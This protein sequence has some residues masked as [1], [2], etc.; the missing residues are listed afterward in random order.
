MFV[1]KGYAKGNANIWSEVYLGGC[2]EW[3]RDLARRRRHDLYLFCHI[4]TP[5]VDDGQRD[6]PHRRQEFM[7][8]CR[9]ALTA[10]DR[11]FVEIRGGWETRFQAAVAAIDPLLGPLAG[12][13]SIAAQDRI[14]AE[15]AAG[16]IP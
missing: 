5:W 2:A 7:E 15:L 3:I 8:R 13:P 14:A 12:A 1:H 11:P 9:A 4:D 16:A 10:H 6:M